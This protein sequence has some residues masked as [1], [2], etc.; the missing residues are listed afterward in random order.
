MVRLAAILVAIVVLG[1][2][3]AS[4]GAFPHTE[5]TVYPDGLAHITTQ[6]EVDPQEPSFLVGLLGAAVDNFVAVDE[7]GVLLAA[8]QAGASS[9]KLETFGSGLVNISYDI[10]DIVSKAGR[11]WTFSVD[12][13][14]EYTI[15]MPGGAV[16]TGMNVIPRNLDII[17]ESVRLEMPG[18]PAEISYITK[19]T[20]STVP[21][22][23]PATQTPPVLAGEQSDEDADI[24]MLVALPLAA[25]AAGVF[26]AV[27]AW[28]RR[29][30]GPAPRDEEEPEQLDPEAV[31]A[32]VPGLRDEDK[33]IVRYICENGGEV[34]E[35][36]LRKKLLRP[37][38]SM[39]RAVQRL[40]R[41][42]AVDI[43]KKDS[44]NQIRIRRGEEPQ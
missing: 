13:D 38:T 21:A 4:F 37:R 19:T 33:E 44:H 1:S 8:E 7:D 34:S 23:P 29:S 31:F 15:L 11:I 6:I 30:G 25:G 22:A 39:W 36:S 5:I 3:G 9:M 24:I 28:S 16:I 14:H 12:I 40:S 20:H 2:A 43:I 18:E 26:V 27:R 32:R 35:S 17:N 10:H 42:G 41:E